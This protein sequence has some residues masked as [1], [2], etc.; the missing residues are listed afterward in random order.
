[1]FSTVMPGTV[2]EDIITRINAWCD[3]CEDYFNLK[4]VM[5]VNSQVIF[6]EMYNV[7]S[8]INDA[9]ARYFAAVRKIHIDDRPRTKKSNSILT[10]KELK[11]IINRDVMRLSTIL[12]P[13]SAIDARLNGFYGQQCQCGSLSTLE[14]LTYVANQVRRPLH[15]CVALAAHYHAI[16]TIDAGTE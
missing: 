15:F 7:A 9:F 11:K 14:I 1:M 6:L 13:K 4:Q 3:N 2:V 8:G 10:A 16:F 12:E 5:P